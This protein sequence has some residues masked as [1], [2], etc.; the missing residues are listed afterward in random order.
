MTWGPFLPRRP[1]WHAVQAVCALK[2][3]PCHRYLAVHV[4]QVLDGWAS[5][6]TAA[7]LLE[8]DSGVAHLWQANTA[9]LLHLGAD[10]PQWVRAHHAGSVQLCPTLRACGLLP[11]PPRRTAAARGRAAVR[12]QRGVAGIR[13]GA[14][15]HR[16]RR[17]RAPLAGQFRTPL[18]PFRDTGPHGCSLGVRQRVRLCW[19]VWLHHLP[20][21]HSSSGGG[22]SDD[23]LAGPQ[24]QL[25]HSCVDPRMYLHL[26][27]TKDGAWLV[28]NASTKTSSEVR[29]L[30][31]CVRR[32]P[33]RRQTGWSRTNL[34]EPRASSRPHQRGRAPHRHAALG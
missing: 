7:L 12:G 26:G 8:C 29:W 9:C 24:R 32:G 18:R 21:A 5:D 25:L 11:A 23:D 33:L 34:R 17:L 28:A 30:A 15:R 4:P 2:L 22:G 14:D 3:S 27:R 13:P 16:A 19:Q 20:E 31:P 10:A 1:A 6:V